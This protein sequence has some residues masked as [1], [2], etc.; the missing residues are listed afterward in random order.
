MRSKYRPPK[1]IRGIHLIVIDP[2][3]RPRH[4]LSAAAGQLNLALVNFLYSPL[5]GI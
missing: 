5:S 4:N 1:L 2:T 3:S